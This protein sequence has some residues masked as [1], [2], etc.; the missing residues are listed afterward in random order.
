VA[1]RYGLRL[2]KKLRRRQRQGQRQTGQQQETF[3]GIPPTGASEQSPPE[4]LR[5]GDY[6]IARNLSRRAAR[7]VAGL[8]PAGLSSS[9]PI[10]APSAATAAAGSRCAPPIGS[11][12]TRSTTPSFCR[13]AAVIFIASAASAALSPVRHRIEAQPSGEITE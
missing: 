7:S 9:S 4:R 3:H 13:S 1:R 5:N 12:T 2:S 6:P 10:A 8:F 11:A